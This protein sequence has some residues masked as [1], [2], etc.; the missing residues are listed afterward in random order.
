MRFIKGLF[1]LIVALTAFFMGVG[2]LLPGAIHVERSALI[3][4][5]PGQIFPYVNNF[6]KFNAWSPWAQRDPAMTYAFTGPDQGAGAAMAWKSE[7][8]GIGSQQIVASVPDERVV[9]AMDFGNIGSAQANFLLAPEAT[10]TRV[11]WSFDT[12]LPY[13]PVARWF[14]LMFPDWIAA[15]YDEG[16]MRL[17]NL[18]EK[19]AA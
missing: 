19:G 10:G 4:A 17:K 9:T 12:D 18:V 2:M 5:Q 15:D 14:G 1:V 13:S 3:A 11:T 7:T 6:R 8:Q 16:L